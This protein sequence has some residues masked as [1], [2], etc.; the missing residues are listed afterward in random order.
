MPRLDL[1]TEEA[2]ALREVLD[3]HLSELRMEIADTDSKD[4]RDG[5][6]ASKDALL[7]IQ[8]KLA[9]EESGG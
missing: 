1:T 4:F 5:L 3:H 9:G 6:K 8:G 2:R 7:R